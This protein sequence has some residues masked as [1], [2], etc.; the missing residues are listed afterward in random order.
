MSIHKIYIFGSTGMLGTYLTK[1]LSKNF[2]IICITR[3]E[4]DILNDNWQKLN[5]ILSSLNENDV[6]INCAGIIPQKTNNNEYNKYIKINTVFPHKLQNITKNVNAKL[7]HITT[8]C[9]FDGV[10]GGYNESHIHNNTNIYGITKSLG[11]PENC[12]II[13]TSII[14]HEL[15]EK[16]NLLEWILSNK[17]KTIYGYTNHIW[18]GV[19][20]LTLSNIIKEMIVKNIFWQ[21]I[22]HIFSPDIITKYE[23]CN[24][25][26][27]IY[28]LN[29][30][31]Q[32]KENK[33]TI[34]RH[35]ISKYKIPFNI[36]ELKIQI[37][38]QKNFNLIM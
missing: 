30:D 37:T 8:D 2:N 7:I 9:V 6:I 27:D 36:P 21:G 22:R 33:I 26:N 38:A 32:K 12:C 28:N 11:E 4:F 20:C 10:K 13:R 17:N 5:K 14:G 29:I 3:N 1:I 35:L 25:V 34:N 16:K 15:K 31:I 18:N 23:L 24:M 19:T